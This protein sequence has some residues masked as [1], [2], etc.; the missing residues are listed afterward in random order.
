MAD[1][2]KNSGVLGNP[3]LLGLAGLLVLLILGFGA[4]FYLLSSSDQGGTNK[5]I[6]HAFELKVNA[7]SVAKHAAMASEG[8]VSAFDSLTSARNEF[9]RHLNILKNGDPASGLAAAPSSLQGSINQVAALWSDRTAHIDKILA[10]KDAVSFLKET[11]ADVNINLQLIQQ[12]NNKIVRTLVRTKTAANE[13]ITAQSQALLVER[14]GHTIDKVVD[15][16]KDQALQ[17][18][19]SRD[20][21]IFR[22]VLRG[23]KNGDSKLFIKAVTD[24]EVQAN[25]ARIEELFRS[26]NTGAK[27]VMTRSAEIV[28]IRDAAA[29]IYGRSS[30]FSPLVEALAESLSEAKDGSSF[31]SVGIGSGLGGSI[32]LVFTIITLLI[33]RQSNANVN[34]TALQ[35]EENQAAILQLLDELADLA[36]GDLRVQA[37]VTESFT[38]AIADSIN[39]SIDQMRGL[40]SKINETSEKVSSAADQTQS[41]VSALSDASQR[42]ASEIADVSEAVDQMAVSIDMVSDNASESSSVAERSVDIASKGAVVVQNTIDGMDNIRGQIQETAKRIKR[43]GESSQEIGDIVAL[44]NDIADQTNILSLNAAIQ[45]SMAGDAGKGFAVV[46]DEVQRLAERSGAA[47]KQISAL[48][49]TIQSDTNEAVSSMEQTTAEVVQGTR[50]AQDAGVALGEIEGVSKSL[51]EVIENIS[52]AARQQAASAGKISNTMKS[53]QEIT[54]VTTH[55]QEE[56]VTAVGNLA[57]MTNELRSSVTGFKLPE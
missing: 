33:Y 41:S 37:T 50:L 6:A 14:M 17:D 35:N 12:E 25:L 2:S 56:A 15:R 53:I 40:V 29:A 27:S 39:F 19:F 31:T 10:R 4:N 3:I 54:S 48:V 52:A 45:A 9:N 47:A 42:Q 5:L 34:Q 22:A 20:S 46:A 16:G 1:E 24:P 32:L 38:G 23:F 18:Q 11:S 30:Q 43:L 8:N 36:D 44:I 13:I 57:E 26:V 51:A 55:G 49:K 28:E 21:Q 7:E